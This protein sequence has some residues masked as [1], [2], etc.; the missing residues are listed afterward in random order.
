[1]RVLALSG[2]AA[3]AAVELA[4]AALPLLRARGLTLSVL[5]EGPPDFDL[6]RPGKDSYEHRSAGALEVAISST[7][8]WALLHEE[9]TP[10][11]PPLKDLIARMDDVDLLLVIGFETATVERL[12]IAEGLDAESLADAVLAALSNDSDALTRQAR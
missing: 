8:R 2:C 1:M 7:Q 6:D 5:L 10:A 4:T 9:E 11:V 12:Q 3:D